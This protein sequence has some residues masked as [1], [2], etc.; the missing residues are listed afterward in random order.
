MRRTAA[1]DQAKGFGVQ[2]RLVRWSCIARANGEPAGSPVVFEQLQPD[3]FFATLLPGSREGTS[4]QLVLRTLVCYR[5]I[6][7]VG[8]RGG[9][10]TPVTRW[11]AGNSRP[12]DPSGTT[13]I[14]KIGNQLGLWPQCRVTIAGVLIA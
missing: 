12:R 14:A 11:A 2:V 13:V 6:D 8:T 1:P 7:P 10:P 3:R 9:R 5:L 4:W